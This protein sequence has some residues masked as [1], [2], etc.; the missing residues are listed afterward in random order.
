MKRLDEG[1]RV[2]GGG[3]FVGGGGGGGRISRWCWGL[4]VRVLA[5]RGA[6]IRDW[7]AAWHG[8]T[9][10]AAGVTTVAAMATVT[11]IAIMA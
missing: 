1:G 10:K 7:V 8:G 5:A 11:S 3:L 4:G 9:T 6:Y 2:E